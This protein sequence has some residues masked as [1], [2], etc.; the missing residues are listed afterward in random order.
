[1]DKKESFFFLVVIFI[2]I[3]LILII[4]YIIYHEK[5]HLEINNNLE[6]NNMFGCQDSYI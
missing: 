6:I 3:L 2:I 1:M 4:S 5:A